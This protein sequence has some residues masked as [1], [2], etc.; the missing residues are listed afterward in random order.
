MPPKTSLRIGL[1]CG[2]VEEHTFLACARSW[3]QLQ[4]WKRKEGEK[5]KKEGRKVMNPFPISLFVHIFAIIWF[6][7]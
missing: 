7:F 5:G 3:V 1:R 6:C 2:L 4:Y